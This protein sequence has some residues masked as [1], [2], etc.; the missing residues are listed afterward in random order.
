MQARLDDLRAARQVSLLGVWLDGETHVQESQAEVLGPAALGLH[1]EPMEH[2]E[3]DHGEVV[4]GQRVGWQGD[5]C[6]GPGGDGMAQELFGMVWS[7]VEVTNAE[8]LR[9]QV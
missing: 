4:A 1:C 8:A 5:G 2:R 3:A 7:H 6:P 9:D